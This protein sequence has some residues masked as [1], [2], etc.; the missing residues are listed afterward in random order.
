MKQ[1]VADIADM[2]ISSDPD[3]QIV[4]YS[5]GS[6]IGVAI[7]DPEKKVGGILHFMLPDSSIDPDKAVD[8]PCMFADTGIPKLFKSAY[9]LGLE[10][11]KARVVVVGGAQVIDS[12]DTFKIGKRNYAAL[13]KIFWKNNVL[14]DAEDVGGTASRT[15][16]MDIGTGKIWIRNAM[17]STKAL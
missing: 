7:Y 9:K 8:K 6:C 4:T 3:S 14:I 10:K 5:L 17:K 16:F 15:L 11:T 1:Y 2:A 13:R 12:A